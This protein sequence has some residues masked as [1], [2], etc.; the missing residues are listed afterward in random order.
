[1]K[2]RS[3]TNA[4][5]S[6]NPPIPQ[7]TATG[8]TEHGFR[9]VSP[10]DGDRQFLA[11]WLARHESP[12]TRRAYERHASRFL[13][14]AGKPIGSVHVGDVQAFTQ[15]LAGQA[16]AS[17]AAAVS[18]VKSMFSFAQE[19]GYVPVNF[20]KAVKAPSVKNTLAVVQSIALQTAPGARVDVPARLP[21]DVIDAALECPGNCIHVERSAD[22]VEV[23]GPRTVPA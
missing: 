15:S 13:R 19:L 18:A 2:R 10:A 14:F 12:N 17:R 16:Q 5:S 3:A 6:L 22:G 9:I 21:L 4:C 7:R 23:A 11:L 20:G 8:P 1:M